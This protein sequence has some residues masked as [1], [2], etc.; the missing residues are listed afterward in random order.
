MSILQKGKRATFFTDVPSFPISFW[1]GAVTSFF[2]NS[3]R[4]G[5]ETGKLRGLPGRKQAFLE[6]HSHPQPLPQQGETWKR[7]QSRLKL[8]A[9]SGVPWASLVAQIGKNLPAMQETWVRSLGW[10]GPLEKG[11]AT[12]S[13]ILDT[14]A[15]ILENSMDRGA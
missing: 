13:S 14:P 2:S 8:A 9:P 15:S 10:E 11:T 1:I 12:H 5:S 6:S 7:N 4:S 3:S